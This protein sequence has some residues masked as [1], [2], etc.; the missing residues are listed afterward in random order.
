MT[1]SRTTKESIKP[2]L[3]MTVTCAQPG[4]GQNLK[5]NQFGV[6]LDAATTDSLDVQE[7]KGGWRDNRDSADLLPAKMRETM[8]QRTDAWE[9]VLK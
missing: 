5:L 9:N 8:K 7:V 1:L 2:A 6:L 4:L 3:A